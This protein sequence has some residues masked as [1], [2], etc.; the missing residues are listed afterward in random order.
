MFEDLEYNPEPTPEPTDITIR[1]LNLPSGHTEIEPF[2][3]CGEG[4]NKCNCNNITE[5]GYL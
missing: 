1:L 2:N 3:R 5:C 4:E